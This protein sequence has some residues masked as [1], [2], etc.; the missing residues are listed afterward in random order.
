MGRLDLKPLK[1]SGC[2]KGEVIPRMNE[3]IEKE[4]NPLVCTHCILGAP[5][6]WNRY[7]ID[8]IPFKRER[9]RLS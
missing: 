6:L 7:K 1:D 8:V 2:R 5:L 4:S 9:R 3:R